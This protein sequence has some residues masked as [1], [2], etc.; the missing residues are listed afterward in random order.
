ME[1]EYSPYAKWF[2]TAFAGLKAAEKLNPVLSGII[3]AHAWQER[4]K[5]L[6][7]AYAILAK[8]HNALGI[9]GPMPTEVSQFL[10]RPFQVINADKFKSATLKEIKNPQISALMKRSPIARI[11]IFS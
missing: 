11:D 10:G 9:T 5:H 8:I 1:K 2:G 4:E 6:S 3:H 7:K